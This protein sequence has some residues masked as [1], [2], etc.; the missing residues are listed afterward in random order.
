M[1]TLGYPSTVTCVVLL[2]ETPLIVSEVTN[3]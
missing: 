3:K 1:L 2:R